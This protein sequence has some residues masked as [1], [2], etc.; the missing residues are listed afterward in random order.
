M[1]QSRFQLLVCLPSLFLLLCSLAQ[2][3]EV[4][5][6][7]RHA[8]FQ[9]MR[10]HYQ[11]YGKGK[12]AVV[13]IHG[14]SCNLS[15]WEENASSLT[16]RARVITIDLPG[17][18]QSDKP[19][20][21]YSMDLFAD[22]INAVLVNA[23]VERAVLIGHSMGTPVIRQ[24]YRRYPAKTQGLVLVDGG[25]RPFADQATMDQ[26]LAGY[27]SPN[28][29]QVIEQFVGFLAGSMRDKTKVE[30][31][32]SSMLST[33]QHVI[34]GAMEGMADPAIWKEQDQI[35][36]PV[37]AIYAQQPIWTPEYKQFVESLIPQLDYQMWEGVSH[38][39]MM[40][41]PA[42]FNETVR[43]FLVKHRL[44]KK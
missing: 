10:V 43:G 24:F 44:V 15:F 28:Y 37:L 14:W 23:R 7:D 40:D 26:F 39:L 42:K 36:V 16:D 21:K 12:E 17:H 32:R 18:G 20:V 5:W 25:L 4:K 30:M 3:S 33:P 27:R 31:I 22:A 6:Q 38:F 1:K 41:E 35:K 19:E 8:D 13:Y 9:G 2:A 29:K 34:V 11:N